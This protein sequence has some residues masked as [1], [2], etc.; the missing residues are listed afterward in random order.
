MIKFR[1]YYDKDKETD[2]LNEMVQKGYAL[3]K[4]FAGFY[5]FEACEPGEYIYQIDFADKLW[6]I[7]KDYRE[8]MEETGVEIVQTWGYWIFLRKKTIDGAFQLYT[9]V[10]SSIAHYT[11]IR[12]M[13][14][15]AIIIELICF[16]ME[17]FATIYSSPL[18]LIAAFLIAIIVVA[19]LRAA[20]KTNHIIAGLKE[21]KGEPS[22]YNRRL[23][24]SP[25]LIGGILLNTCAL[26]MQN[27]DYHI[28]KLV[29]QIFAIVLMLIG[30]YRIALN[31]NQ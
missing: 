20:I 11:K 5:K 23:E 27:P 1:F 25:V 17:I 12:N 2:W 4:F 14:K 8:F 7:S 29:I 30:L 22:Q 16:F 9:D 31:R 13:F 15:G 21:R 3:K 28:V 6:G 18:F 19:M 24:Q 10:D 26:A